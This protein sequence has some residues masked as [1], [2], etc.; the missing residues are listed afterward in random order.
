MHAEALDLLL[1]LLLQPLLMVAC[2]PAR[3]AGASCATLSEGFMA[4]CQ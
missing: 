1:V 2:Q 3:Q 4:S